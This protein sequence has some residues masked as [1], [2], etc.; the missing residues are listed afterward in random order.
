MAETTRD[1]ARGDR[2]LD[3]RFIGLVVRY[4]DDSIDAS[5]LA[6][7]QRRLRESTQA[8]DAFA[9]YCMHAQMIREAG[10]ADRLAT[11]LPTLTAT[12]V[13]GGLG[14]SRCRRT[15]GRRRLRLWLAGSVAAA[16]VVSLGIYWS[17]R[18]AM[19][20]RRIAT[21]V[22]SID[23]SWPDG[24]RRPEDGAELGKGVV[25]LLGGLVKL[26]LGDGTMLTLEGPGELELVSA[27]LTRLHSG[28]LAATVDEGSEGVE[29]ETPA[30]RVVEPAAA[31]GV[32]VDSGGMT[33]VCVFE[34]E[35]EVEVG[36][37]RRKRKRKR[38]VP[39]GDAVRAAPGGTTLTASQ[40]DARS[41]SRAWRMHAGIVRTTGM[42]RFAPPGRPDSLLQLEDDDRLVILP[43]KRVRL[44]VETRV[45]I[46]EPGEYTGRGVGAAG[47]LAA[48]RRVRSYLVQFNPVDPSRKNETRRLIGS[49]EFQRPIV[50]VIT[51]TKLLKATDRKIGGHPESLS[52]PQ[53]GLER[54]GGRD[55]DTLTLTAD[56]RSLAFDLRVSGDHVDQIRVLV[57]ASKP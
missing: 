14:T 22:Q 19:E 51:E 38:R 49:V 33:D 50:A 30:L 9:T 6:E 13:S 31:F 3:D 43:E 2:P 48:G 16:I 35:V 42:I 36:P 28:R 21:L 44:K 4:F 32:H 45:N 46:T 15:P 1:D 5:E 29:I 26:R 52:T 34:G 12:D 56:R 25:R 20:S 40:Y 23:V 55:R 47:K 10:A 39:H 27:D 11:L 37:E 18:L 54:R 17:Y 57:D 7:L 41:Y 8:C 53:R 24:A